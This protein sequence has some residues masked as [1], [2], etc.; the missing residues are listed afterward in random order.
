MPENPW[1]SCLH[2][3]IYELRTRHV[4]GKQLYL[5]KKSLVERI[6]NVALNH[7]ERYVRDTIERSEIRYQLLQN[8]V[9]FNIVYTKT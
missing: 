2:E 9:C 1:A 8:I 6:T 5:S 7:D 3:G 4:H